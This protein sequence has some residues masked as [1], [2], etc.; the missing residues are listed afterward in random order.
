MNYWLI[1]S[2]FKTRSWQDVLMSGKFSLYGIRNYQARKNISEMQE[3]DVALFYHD[4]KIHGKMEVAC[5]AYPDPT[6][7]ENWLSIDFTPVETFKEP[8]TIE[9]IKQNEL[10]S[11]SAIFKQ[12]RLSVIKLSKY[13]FEIFELEG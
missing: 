7:F 3:G 8:I 9:Q 10:L 5:Q 2:P 4:K 6:S 1:K 13:E 12:P 11:S